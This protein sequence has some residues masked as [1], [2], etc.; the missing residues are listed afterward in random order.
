MLSIN[1]KYI[2]RRFLPWFK[3]K[4]RTLGLL[5][6]IAN[7]IKG[8]NTDLISFRNTTREFTSVSAQIIHFEYYL[9][10]LL[11]YDPILNGIYI[12]N[13]ADIN[14]FY[15]RNKSELRERYFYNKAEYIATSNVSP[16]YYLKNAAEFNAELDYIVWIPNSV[17][18]DEDELISQIDKYNLAGKKYEIRLY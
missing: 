17:T 5:Y 1:F 16:R 10:I 4:P 3:R 18:Y 2:F 11:G 7:V 12:E 14:Y 9:N 8:L 15:L 13:F 6:S